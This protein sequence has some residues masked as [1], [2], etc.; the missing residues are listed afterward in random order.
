ML[1][2]IADWWHAKR[3]PRALAV[4]DICAVDSGNGGFGIVKI[5]RLDPS[6]VHVALYGNKFSQRPS[7]VDTRILQFGQIG[8]EGANGIGHLPL[9]R[10]TF[11]QWHPVR[12]ERAEVTEDELFGYRM[13]VE[14]RGGTWG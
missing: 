13:W 10:A 3:L 9:S 1:K 7:H 6:I 8:E 4:G 5:L 12:I 11:A 2:K 14:H